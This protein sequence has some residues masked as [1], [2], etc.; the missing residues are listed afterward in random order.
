[1]PALEG[2]SEA[3]FRMGEYE[4]A[5]HY[6]LPIVAQ[7]P[8]DEHYL[9]LLNLAELVLKLDPSERGLPS[10]ERARRVRCTTSSSRWRGREKCALAG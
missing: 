2:A 3:A 5:R 7:K 8:K 9:E 1:M 4:I 10:R 6:L